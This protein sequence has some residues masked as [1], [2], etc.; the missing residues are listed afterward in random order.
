MD[1]WEKAIENMQNKLKVIQEAISSRDKNACAGC[2]VYASLV[3]YHRIQEQC[4]DCKGC[5]RIATDRYQKE[6]E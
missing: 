3:R 4:S 2:K 6:Q 5:I 1:N